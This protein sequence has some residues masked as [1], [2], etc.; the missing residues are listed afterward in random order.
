MRRKAADTEPGH[1]A[2]EEGS[3]DDD[4]SFNQD[5]AS[6]V[7]KSETERA[8][9]LAEQG[10]VTFNDFGGAHYALQQP[11]PVECVYVTPKDIQHISDHFIVFVWNRNFSQIIEYLRLRLQSS[12]HSI[13]LVTDERLSSTQ[14]FLVGRFVGIKVLLGNC[15]DT[16]LLV[17][18]GA[19]RALGIVVF[20]QQVHSSASSKSPDTTNTVVDS[21][22]ILIFNMSK[23]L[24][25]NVPCF[26]EVAEIRSFG[27]LTRD[28]SLLDLF[29]AARSLILFSPACCRCML[30]CSH[31]SP[32]PHLRR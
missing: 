26:I 12:T 29:Y 6:P 30:S 17:H 19:E 24:R 10:A 15:S 32:Q 25:N 13:L 8:L 18:A 3:D 27:F 14:W 11:I 16:Q 9:H 28:N 31:S 4:M 7:H 23:M 21:A 5:F 2:I 20:P 22:S 1:A